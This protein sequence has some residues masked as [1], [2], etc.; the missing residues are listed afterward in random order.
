[1]IEIIYEIFKLAKLSEKKC[2]KNVNK[3]HMYS[4]EFINIRAYKTCIQ[5][6]TLQSL[7]S[8]SLSVVA[9]EWRAKTAPGV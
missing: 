9:C 1:M 3:H 4:Q 8:I 2:S 5:N 6:F 7:F